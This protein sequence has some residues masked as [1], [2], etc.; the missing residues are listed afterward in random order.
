MSRYHALLPAEEIAALDAALQQPPAPAIRANTLKIRTE[1]IP[2]WYGWDIEQLP[3]CESGWR[4]ETPV[5]GLSQTLEYKQGQFYIQDAA[6]MLPAEMFSAADAPLILDLAAA[7]GGKTTHLVSCFADRATIVAN[8]NS[9][10]RIAALR[11]NLQVWGAMN[12]LVTNFSGEVFGEWFPETFDKVLLDAPCSGDT[13][14]ENKGRK[15]RTVSA[16]E[17]ASICLRQDVLLESALRALKVGGEIVYATCTL[18][19]EEDEGTLTRLLE[20]FPA[21]TIESVEL[22]PPNGVTHFEGVAYHPSVAQAVRVFPHQFHSSGFFAARIRKTAA[23]PHTQDAAPQRSL[24]ESGYENLPAHDIAPIVDEMI[25]VF[26]FDFGPV[27]DAIALN[28][29]QKDDLVYAIPKRIVQHFGDLPH[30]AIGFLIGQL[31]GDDFLPSHELITRFETK[32]LGRR[33]A[34]SPQESEKWLAG[35]D[36]RG[37]EAEQFPSSGLVLLEDERGRFLGRGTVQAQRIRNLMPKRSLA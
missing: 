18:A 19:P 36:L 10:K 21:A 14:R 2:A 15:K 20:K 34:L 28:F 32:F 35:Y 33:V 6:S 23:L 16:K 4:F 8:D 30:A 3:F 13:L 9:A 1:E 24:N 31:A 26:G 27:I 12:T 22:L 17:Q 25:D 29:W 5:K 37:F 7:P 11:S